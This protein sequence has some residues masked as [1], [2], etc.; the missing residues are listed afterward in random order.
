MITKKYIIGVDE[1]GR[2][3]IAGPL[4]VCACAVRVGVDLLNLFPKGVLKDSKKLTENQRA[5]IRESLYQYVTRGDVI[6]GIGE[7]S[8]SCIDSQGLS[9]SIRDAIQQALEKVV[10]EGVSRD[11]FVYLDGS[12]KAEECYLNQ[13]TVIK[14]DEKII[15]ISLAS[16]IAKQYRDNLMKKLA[17]IFPEYSFDK[18]MGYGTKAHYE[19]LSTYGM[20]KEH[21]RSFLKKILN[22][23]NN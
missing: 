9:P 20:T 8:A 13:Q 4:V 23:P 1:V 19:A 17:H 5:G 2:G 12:L 16:I 3:P 6:F 7:V 15:E 10:T 11:S 22:G 14:G 18:H 21:R